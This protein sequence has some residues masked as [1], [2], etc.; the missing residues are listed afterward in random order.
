[1]GGTYQVAP[2]K[3]NKDVIDYMKSR[4]TPLGTQIKRAEGGL[5]TGP[6]TGKS[7]SI[8]ARLSNGEFVINADMVKKL[9]LPFLNKLNADAIK[10]TTIER[11]LSKTPM[12]STGISKAQELK[13]G[14]TEGLFSMMQNKLGSMFG[15]NVGGA[16][17][18]AQELKAGG[19]DGLLSMMQNKIGDMFGG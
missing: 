11:L 19:T 8:P 9:G 13:A 5:V 1:M 17:S 15:G 10:G 2:D 4:G 18:K 16:V 3:S 6:G 12:L 14:G 7:D